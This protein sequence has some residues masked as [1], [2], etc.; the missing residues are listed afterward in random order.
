M[1]DENPYAAPASPIGPTGPRRR[2]RLG[3]LAV[4]TAAIVLATL[5]SG[6]KGLLAS[7]FA[8]GSWW[9]YRS[10]RLPPTTEAAR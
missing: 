6:G 1:S 7:V 9:A 4:G 8:V 2:A 5:L 3:P 10:R